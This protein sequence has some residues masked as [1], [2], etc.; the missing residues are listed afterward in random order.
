MDEIFKKDYDITHLTTFGIPA[1][2]RL[3]AEYSD[4]KELTRIS[5]TDEYICNEVM[6]IGGGSN[7]LFLSEFDGLVLHS[8]VKGIEAYEKHD[9]EATAFVIAGAGERWTDLVDWCVDHGYAGLENLAGIPGEVGAS[10]VQ[11]VGAYGVEAGDRI[12]NVECFDRETRKVVT[13]KGADCGFAYRDSRFKRE[14]KDR[15]FVIRVSFRLHKSDVASDLEYRGLH[16]LTD[17]LGHTPSIREVR[18]EVLRIRAA[19]LPS[20]DLIGS[21]G[22]FFRNPIVRR[23]YYEAEIKYRQSDTPCWPAPDDDSAAGNYRGDP[24]RVKIPAGWL[25]EKAGLK[26]KSVG[27]AFVYPDNCLVIANRGDATASD[28][29]TLADIVRREV[30]RRFHVWLHPEVN[31]IDS[32]I[33]ITVLGSGTSKGVPEVGCDCDVCS[34]PDFRDKRLRCSAMVETMGRHILIDVSPDFRYQALRAGIYDVDA[35]LITHSHYDHVGGIDDLRPFCVQHEIPLYVSPAVDADLRR[36]YD[37]CFRDVLYP[38]V[39]R[40]VLNPLDGR[41]FSIDGLEIIPIEVEHGKGHPIFGYR[42]GN[43]AYITDAKI[44][45]DD[46]REKLRGLDVLVINALRDRDHFSHLTIQ[47]ALDVIADLKPRRTFFTHLCHEAGRH[48]DLLQ[49]LPAGV[50]P[51]YDGQEIWVNP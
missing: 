13:I 32:R 33:K 31:Y 26:G 14:W 24:S 25:I 41:P 18:D 9:E 40:L 1:R 39:P 28:V 4:W 37:Y 29:A 43:F 38:G 46:E 36:R 12:H 6:H 11:N 42:I 16:D 17:R 51:L 21:A 34:S 50:E 27:G 3:F 30:N 23:A 15:Y 8:L 22:S 47:E 5:R 44:I 49:R 35:V 45:S 48:D 7:L 2:A 19:K 10:P 20:P